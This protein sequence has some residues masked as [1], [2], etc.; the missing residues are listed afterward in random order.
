MNDIV[1][2]FSSNFKIS[3]KRKLEFELENKVSYSRFQGWKY[4]EKKASLLFENVW[5]YCFS[6]MVT[7]EE[8]EIRKW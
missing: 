6:I 4:Q 2:S 7:V 3:Q 8:K 5:F 1:E